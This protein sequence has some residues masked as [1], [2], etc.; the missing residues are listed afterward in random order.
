MEKKGSVILVGAGCGRGLITVRGLSVLKEADT[1]VYDDLIDEN[2]LL[3]TKADCE[4]IYVG[5]RAS[6][7]S[8]SQDEINALLADKAEEGKLVV[9]LKGGDPFVFGRGGEEILYLQQRDIPFDVIPGVTS[10]IAVPGHAGIPVTHRGLARSVTIVT[11][12][13]AAGKEVDYGALAALEGTLVFLM[14]AGRLKEIADALLT[15]GKAPDTPAAVISRGYSGDER[16][17]NGKLADIV[18]KAENVQT[19]AVILVGPAAEFSLEGTI[20]KELRGVR[21]TVTGTEG[22][23]KKAGGRLSRLGADVDCRPCLRI[24]PEYENIPES[25]EEF[26]WLIFTSAN[27][28]EIF[29]RGLAERK[30]DLRGLAALKFACIGPGTS[31]KL[32]EY[33]IYADFQ[34]SVYTAEALGEELAGRLA[35]E[36][37]VLIL[38]AREGSG[39]LPEAFRR[40]DIFCAE[41]AVYH[42]QAIKERIRNF[43]AD[44][45]YLVFGS[46]RGAETFLESA[47]LSERTV[48]VCIGPLT[49]EAFERMREKT[50]AGG[51]GPAAEEKG[52]AAE[53]NDREKRCFVPE[54]YTIEGIVREIVSHRRAEESARIT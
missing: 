40:R 20:R 22:F 3:E 53:E 8:K 43:R 16:R 45:D 28:V 4:Q 7:Q 24:V 12:H 17:I 49:A 34:P 36:K 2:L 13:T 6:R 32:A 29:F 42:T 50:G 37:R 10:A 25:F 15:N 47:Q 23:V 39:D 35:S 38:R 14:G 26:D 46:A 48:P 19:P 51:L 54:E 30:K 11:G 33:G 41:R 18:K 1:V 21:V 9:R 31:Q 44:G 5:K 27:G 52:P